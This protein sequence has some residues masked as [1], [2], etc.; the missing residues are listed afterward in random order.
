MGVC[1]GQLAG[2]GGG[3]GVWA[4]WLW[5]WLILLNV[6][7]CWDVTEQSVKRFVVL[8]EVGL[9]GWESRV[10]SPGWSLVWSVRVRY[11]LLCSYFDFFR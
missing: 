6:I 1:G 7:F 2:V 10:V 8:E 3:A 11:T 5:F 4:H 9:G